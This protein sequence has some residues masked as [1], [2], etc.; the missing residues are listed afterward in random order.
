MYDIAFIN[1]SKISKLILEKLDLPKT[2]VMLKKE[3]NKHRESI[4]R[5]LL[6]LEKKGYVKCQNPQD[7]NYRYYL[8][9]SKGKE[10]LEKVKQI[11]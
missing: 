1:R 7:N 3:L 5:V 6:Q 11:K 8:I 2:A 4:S 10:L 9:T